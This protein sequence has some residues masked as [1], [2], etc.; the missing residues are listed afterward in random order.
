MTGT[1]G[2]AVARTLLG[3]GV[4]TITFVDNS[5][6]SYSNPVRQSLYE[7]EDCHG[8]GLPKAK[9]AAEKLRKIFPVV[10]TEGIQMNIPMPGH[11]L[12][13]AEIDE[14]F[15]RTTVLAPG[16]HIV[17]LTTSGDVV[18]LQEPLFPKGSMGSGRT[19]IFRVTPCICHARSIHWV[20]A[21][22]ASQMLACFANRGILRITFTHIV[23]LMSIGPWL[24]FI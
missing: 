4:R 5:T 13:G 17:R 3:W 19:G 21:T 1:L 10:N 22:V 12:S 9:A 24:V 11:P 7:F 16:A 23:V 8:G 18:T 14:V 15:L 20:R 2:C 6:I